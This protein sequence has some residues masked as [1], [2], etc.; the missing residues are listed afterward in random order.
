VTLHRSPPAWS[1]RPRIVGED[2]PP[3][4]Q[5]VLKS[6]WD[7]R[8]GNCRP[9]L[10]ERLSAHLSKCATCSRRRRMEE[11]LF[12]SMA[13]MRRRWVAPPHLRS[14]VRRVLEAERRRRLVAR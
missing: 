6:L 7:Y 9:G 1:R 5:E 8:D 3:E 10:A 4:C 11:R 2:E 13:E 12:A 14:R